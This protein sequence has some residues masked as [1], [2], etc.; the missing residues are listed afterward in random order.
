MAPTS[1]PEM[2]R[3]VDYGETAEAE[4]AAKRDD[5][6][7]AG[8]LVVW[9]VDPLAETVTVYR[10]ATAPVTFRRGDAADAEPAVPG[11]RMA[12]DELFPSP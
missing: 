12:V 8:T 3:E 2:R 1:A 10:R 7:A 4:R 5:Y 9:D 11:W 6:F